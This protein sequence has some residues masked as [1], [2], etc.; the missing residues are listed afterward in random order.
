MRWVGGIWFDGMTRSGRDR[1]PVTLATGYSDIRKQPGHHIAISQERLG[2]SEVILLDGLPSTPLPRSV[3]FEMRYAADKR[4]ATV[5]LDMAAYSDLVSIEE[6]ALYA[7]A[8]PGWTGIPQCR[9]ALGLAD[10]NSWSPWETRMRLVWVLDAGLPRPLCNQPV[11]DRAGQLIGAPDILDSEAGVVGEYDGA[12]HLDHHRRRRDRGREAGFR[13]VGLEYFTVMSGD[14]RDEIVVRMHEARQRARWESEARR[15]W[16][17]DL[18]RWW[19]PTSGVDQR[20]ALDQAQ[21]ERLLRLRRRT[22]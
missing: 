15:E 16:T 4:E 11:F 10:E 9:D 17:L 12:V 13:R 7:L 1:L 22:S 8:H 2:E 14:T 21:R 6:V 18:P 5:V 19:T 3:C 20:R